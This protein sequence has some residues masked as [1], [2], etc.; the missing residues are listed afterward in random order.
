ME[1]SFLELLSEFEKKLPSFITE[2]D[3]FLQLQICISQI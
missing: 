3:E 2:S 1:P